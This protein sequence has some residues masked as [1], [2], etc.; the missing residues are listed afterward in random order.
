MRRATLLVLAILAVAVLPAGTAAGPTKDKGTTCAL[1]TRLSPGNEVPPRTGD[2]SG[3][4]KI[5]I[6]DTTLKFKTRIR[7]DGQTFT[8]GHVH[9]AAAG[10]NGPVVVT[11][12]TGAALT[13]ERIKSKGKVEILKALAEEICGNPAG[14]YVNYH[15]T[16]N[17]GGAIR[18]QLG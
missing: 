1:K 6:H 9:R 18:G 10:V 11:L 17:P 13:D 7:N 3:R 14:F 16:L 2:A 15:T 8:A 4:T 12:L 5:K